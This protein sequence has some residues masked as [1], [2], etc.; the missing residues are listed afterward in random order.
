[1]L[2]GTV[3]VYDEHVHDW[4]LYPY[5]TFLKDLFYFREKN[6]RLYTYSSMFPNSNLLYIDTY[7][8]NHTYFDIAI[9]ILS[10][11]LILN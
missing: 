6:I 10:K 1:M 9:L 3:Q 2:H 7:F 4:I 8:G 11:T 5:G